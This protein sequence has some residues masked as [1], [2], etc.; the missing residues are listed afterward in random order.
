[1]RSQ[2]PET[3]IP[4]PVS[5]HP[6]QR[7]FH[8]GIDMNASN[9]RTPS[10]NEPIIVFDDEPPRTERLSASFE[11]ERRPYVGSPELPPVEHEYPDI[12]REEI[13]QL[14]LNAEPAAFERRRRQYSVSSPRSSDIPSPKVTP[15][16]PTPSTPTHQPPDLRQLISEGV[17]FS[18]LHIS[19]LLAIM[20]QNNCPI[21]QGALEK[22]EIVERVEEMASFIIAQPS[23]TE[24]LPKVRSDD[25]DDCHICFERVADYCLVPCGHTGFCFMCARKMEACPF[26]KSKVEHTQKLWKV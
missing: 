5:H 6:G 8:N 2:I 23:P 7:G 9:W 14:H 4:D 17:D 22:K 19:T 1:M 20:R 3:A 11:R 24:K 12:L 16:L 21:P 26:C 18:T 15:T 10:I 13:D 25:E